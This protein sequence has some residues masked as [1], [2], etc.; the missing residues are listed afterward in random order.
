MRQIGSELVDA[1]DKSPG[2][3]VRGFR[4]WLLGMVL[5]G[6]AVRSAFSLLIATDLPP[7]VDAE[8]YH[9]TAESIANGDGLGYNPRFT[10]WPSDYEWTP[11]GNHPPLF[12]LVLAGGMLAGFES[13]D[14]QRVL[15]SVLA[16]AAVGLTGLAA[17]RI[18]GDLVALVAAGIVALH[19]VWFQYPGFMASDALYGVVV[20]GL[21]SAGL[22]ALERSNLLAVAGMGLM[23]GAAVMVRSE[24][25]LFVP[26]LVFPVAWCGARRGRLA[27]VLV[28]LGVVAVSI[29]PWML[30]VRSTYGVWSLSM[31]GGVTMAIANCPE[32]YFGPGTGSIDCDRNWLIRRTRLSWGMEQIDYIVAVD[33]D[34][35]ASA[36]DFARDN[37][38]ELPRVLV[39]RVGRTLGIYHIDHALQFDAKIGGAP[40]YQRA[41]LWVHWAMMPLVALG[42]VLV[43]RGP[44]RRQLIV[45]MSGPAVA[46][47]TTLAIYGGTRIRVS[48]EPTIAV[49]A[50]VAIVAGWERAGLLR[51]N[52]GAV[53][54]RSES[55]LVQT[56]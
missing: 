25:I 55:E 12:P 43:A 3:A 23:V 45:L 47:A 54:P 15:L 21:L 46:L 18:G 37:V 44:R 35:R 33:G 16:A 30:W 11:A 53:R 10:H 36:A 13:W 38:D 42:G 14:E 24:A 26:F 41:A 29:A 19:P 50:A 2:R 22:L 6:A 56:A 52:R 49:L 28:G 8:I 5:V 27:R 32:S 51:R 34:Y 1:S 20:A 4:Y 31:N 39:A 9:L 48:A 40:A 7:G 17:R